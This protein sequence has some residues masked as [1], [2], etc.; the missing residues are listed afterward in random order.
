DIFSLGVV[1]YEMVAGE[2]PFAAASGAETLVGILEREPKPL[3][4]FAQ[5]MP[6]E[7]ERIVEK[8]LRKDRDE[9]YQ[10][11][12]QLAVD[13]KALKQEIDVE[14]RLQRT[15]ELDGGSRTV[16]TTAGGQAGVATLANAAVRTDDRATAKTISSGEYLTNEGKPG[17]LWVAV[18]GAAVLVLVAAIAYYFYSRSAEAMDSVPG[19]PFVN[20][21]RP[22]RNDTVSTDAYNAYFRGRHFI[23]SGRPGIGFFEEAIKLDPN[24]ALAYAALA[25]AALSLTWSGQSPNRTIKLLSEG[26]AAVAKAL[27]IDNKLAEA[28]AALG[29][30]SLFEWDWLRAEKEFERAIELNPNYDRHDTDYDHYL[31]VMKRFDEAV[32]DNRRALELD[33]LSLLCN[34][35]LAISL[36]FARRYDEAIEQSHKTLGLDQNMTTTYRW[37]AMSYEQKGLYRE[38][39]EAYLKT[40][41][42]VQ[43]IGPPESSVTV[44]GAVRLRY[45]RYME[46]EAAVREAYAA[47]GWKGFW[48]KW[49]DWTNAKEKERNPYAMAEVYARL[50][51]KDQAF[52]WLERAY[53]RRSPWLTFLNGDPTWDGLRSEP[54]YID[55]IRRM[56]LEP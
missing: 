37:L 2:S 7:L 9:R 54:R 3:G 24:Y 31:R 49:G 53:E 56:G 44:G 45:K 11:A 18:S 4:L 21:Q 39:V 19:L 46:A 8:A 42:F 34:G 36:Y 41:G 25:R 38:A 12:G 43:L 48:R 26:K 52:A 15:G 33:P 28:H 5:N 50:G 16:R 30:I 29:N 1:L 35:N 17:K 20:E 27:E 13:L 14:A 10:M 40:A 6:G 32:A 23:N 47:S 55:I 51:E 22:T